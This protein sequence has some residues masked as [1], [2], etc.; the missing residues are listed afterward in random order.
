MAVPHVYLQDVRLTP[1]LDNSHVVVSALAVD[2]AHGN[3]VLAIV[4]DDSAEQVISSATGHVGTE[5]QVTIPDVHTWSPSDPCGRKFGDNGN[6]YLVTIILF[7]GATQSAPNIS[8]A[9]ALSNRSLPGELDRID[10][11]T[12]VR[13]FSEYRD[14]N[15]KGAVQF[16][17]NNDPSFLYDKLADVA[18]DQEHHHK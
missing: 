12:G 14:V 1:D 9:S 6:H 15:C 18:P 13:N 2:A 4:T 8:R 3:L 5:L 10:S 11:Y 16:C 7:D 17:L